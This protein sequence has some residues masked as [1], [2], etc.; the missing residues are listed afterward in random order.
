MIAIK[1]AHFL[2][3]SSQLFQCPA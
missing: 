3:S 1:D 2:T